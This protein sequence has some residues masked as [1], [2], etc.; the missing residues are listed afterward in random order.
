MTVLVQP[1]YVLM[2]SMIVP[3]LIFLLLLAT[4]RCGHCKQLAPEYEK[5]AKQ[6]KDGTPP[7]PLATVDATKE[8]EISQKYGVSGYP[9][10]FIFRKGVKYE[11]K[12]ERTQYGRCSQ[13]TSKNLTAIEIS[14]SFKNNGEIRSFH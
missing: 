8:P 5:A 4:F 7:I 1:T 9:T 10:M 11:Y 3:F 13:S 6:L 12:G 2:Y 14:Y